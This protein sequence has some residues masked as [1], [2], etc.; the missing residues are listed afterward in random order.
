MD[1]SVLMSL[2]ERSPPGPT[3]LTAT[4]CRL[5]LAVMASRC[6][7]YDR[8]GSPENDTTIVQRGTDIQ[9]VRV[10]ATQQPRVLFQTDKDSRDVAPIF[11]PAAT[12]T[13]QPDLAIQFGDQSNLR[14]FSARLNGQ[15]PLNVKPEQM[16]VKATAPTQARQVIPSWP[17]W[18]AKTQTV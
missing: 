7:E 4:S 10:G 5:S 6:S 13:P 14:S 16:D 12:G 15:R 1:T 2:E 18:A 11:R 8:H 9:F 17:Y 3:W